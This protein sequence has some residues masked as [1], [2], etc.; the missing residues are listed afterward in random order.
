MGLYCV[1]LGRTTTDYVFRGIFSSL[2]IIRL[3]SF[4]LH[5]RVSS[6]FQG[7]VQNHSVLLLSL[8]IKR[9][10]FFTYFAYHHILFSDR[11][12]YSLASV[13]IVMSIFVF[14]PSSR[15]VAKLVIFIPFHNYWCYRT[16]SSIF[17]L[18]YAAFLRWPCTISAL[19]IFGMQRYFVFHIL[20]FAIFC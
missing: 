7:F 4:Y 14:F 11:V 2:R 6:S 8:C 13:H 5:S 3:R 1:L 12:L 9:G 15:A 17:L 10:L 19:P 20:F 18:C 16:I